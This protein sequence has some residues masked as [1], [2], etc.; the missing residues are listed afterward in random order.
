L[1]DRQI[2]A[3][4]GNARSTVM[5]DMLSVDY[6]GKTMALVDRYA[7]EI[8]VAQVFVAALGASHYNYV[9]ASLTQT[10]ADWLGARVRALE[11]FGGVPRAIVAD[12]LKKFFCAPGEITLGPAAPRPSLALG[13]A[14]EGDR[15]RRCAALWSTSRFESAADLSINSGRRCE[16]PDLR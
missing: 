15:H 2:G 13:V 12:N 11:Y 9:E 3:V 7:G 16:V 1:S 14:L 10:V 8:K 5:G 4:L 6:A